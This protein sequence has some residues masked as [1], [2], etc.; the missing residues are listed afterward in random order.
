MELTSK[1]PVQHFRCLVLTLLLSL[2]SGAIAQAEDFPLGSLF[3]DGKKSSLKAA[4][5]TDEF[6]ASAEDADLGIW[7]TISG[8]ENPVMVAPGVTFDFKNVGGSKVT[9]SRATNDTFEA[10]DQARGIRTTGTF[11]PALAQGRK[12]EDGI[13]LHANNL[14]TLDLAEIRQAGNLPD[15]QSFQ[16]IAERMGLN[17]TA[18]QAAWPTG[19]VRIVVLVINANPASPTVQGSVNGVVTPVTQI[20]GLWQVEKAS[21]DEL[22]ADGKHASLDVSLPGTATH[23]VI[24]STGGSGGISSDHA[25]LSGARL[26][27][28]AR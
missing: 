20:D 12:V 24:A 16:L 11:E 27:Y 4:I 17:D 13:G 18:L 9:H 5:A 28:R 26:A 23:V 2:T 19:S 14:F 15:D 22:K 25:V 3:D 21:Q 7:T 8:F 10:G 1:M 6:G